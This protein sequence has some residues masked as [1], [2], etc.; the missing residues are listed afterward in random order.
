MSLI[1]QQ[2][3]LLDS[4]FEIIEEQ[5]N[6]QTSV[7][8]GISFHFNSNSLIKILNAKEEN[9]SLKISPSLLSQIRYY[10]L[11]DQHQLFNLQSQLNFITYFDNFNANKPLIKTTL[12]LDGNILNQICDRCLEDV[13]LLS[14]LT[15]AHYWLIEQILAQLQFQFNVQKVKQWLQIIAW[16]MAIC[17]TLIM[18]IFNLANLQAHLWLWIAPVIVC[19]LLQ[20]GINKL[21]WL[22]LSLIRR[23]LLKQVLYGIFSRQQ[24]SQKRTLNILSELGL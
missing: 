23:W 6:P 17:I 5:L 13:N 19:F 10:C 16:I 24:K 12:G 22:N 4:F 3:L 14:S 1:K 7:I 18:V 20:W 8:H 9:I 15:M 11:I 21:L 2:K